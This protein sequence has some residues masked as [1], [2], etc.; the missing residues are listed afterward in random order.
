MLSSLLLPLLQ[1]TKLNQP[2]SCQS[3]HQCSFPLSSVSFPHQRLV[4]KR[5]CCT[6]LFSKLT[7][8]PPPKKKIWQDNE[9]H[10][11]RS[12]RCCYTK[13]QRKHKCNFSA[14]VYL[15]SFD[16]PP[17]RRVK[18]HAPHTCTPFSSRFVSFFFFLLP[19]LWSWLLLPHDVWPFP[20][21]ALPKCSSWCH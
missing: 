11:K 20:T 2:V 8:C 15:N 7:L 4:C 3:P 5:M 19:I 18:Q 14:N 6:E 9:I 10:T 1:S 13:T 21:V 12:R 17:G 16:V